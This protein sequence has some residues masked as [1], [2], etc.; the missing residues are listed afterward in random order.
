ML[1]PYSLLNKDNTHTR[2]QTHAH[3][4]THVCTQ[5]QH[6]DFLLLSDCEQAPIG[7]IIRT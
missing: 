2:T 1:S 4:L 5:T 3:T 6:M 7:Y